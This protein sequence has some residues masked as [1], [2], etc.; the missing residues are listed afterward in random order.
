MDPAELTPPEFAL[1]GGVVVYAAALEHVAVAWATALTRQ[2]SVGSGRS[3]EDVREE[4]WTKVIGQRSAE[5]VK[6]CWKKLEQ[7][8]ADVCP[9]ERRDYLN[10]LTSMDA[11]AS[12][13]SR[14][15]GRRPRIDWLPIT[16]TSALHGRAPRTP[17]RATVSS[18]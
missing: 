8:P 3:D 15:S 10:N 5:A 1:I 2:T 7:L 12:V 18:W 4:I 6:I 16:R 9:P 11:V 13:G 14:S 17:D